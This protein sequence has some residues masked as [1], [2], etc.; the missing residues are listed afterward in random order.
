MIEMLQNISKHAAEHNGMCEGIIIISV[1]N[2]H[3][4]INT[5][6]YIDNKNIASLKEKLENLLH[7]DQNDLSEIYKKKL[8]NEDVPGENAGVG[9][10]EITKYST[11]KLKYDFKPVTDSLSFFS[12]SITI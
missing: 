7:M 1:K 6:N 12:L 4:T 10:I 5:G 3:Y 2:N 8:F 11:E 9:L